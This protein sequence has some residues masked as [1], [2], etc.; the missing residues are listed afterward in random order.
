MPDYPRILNAGDSALVVE[1][2]DAVDAD[3][4]QSVYDFTAA[5]EL[6]STFG[7][8]EIIP[9]YR[10]ALVN[11]DPLVIS[12]VDVESAISRA[13]SRSSATDTDERQPLIFTLPVQY[14][15]EGGPDLERV[16][17]HNNV[18]PDEVVRIHTS[19]VYRVF[20]L[21]FLPGF[22]Y[23]G[24]MDERIATPRLATP[25]ISVPAGAVGIAE[26]QTGVYPMESPGG[27][28]L[29]GLTPVQFFDP[30]VSPPVPI[31]P[32]SFIRFES[33]TADE[34]EKIKTQITAGEYVIPADGPSA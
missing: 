29:I 16:A 14:G 12:H 32:G 34:I 3:I 20:M 13:I 33:K 2:G 26:S 15:G 24:G 17:E 30:N 18:T 10:S 27:W 6:D 11:F 22:P 8:G 23:L 5:L 19:G 31:Q 1:F 9:T 28:N 4:N 25:R 21:G 7:V